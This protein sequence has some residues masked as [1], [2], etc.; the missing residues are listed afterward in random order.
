MNEDWLNEVVNKNNSTGPGDDWLSDT[1]RK[2]NAMTQYD[3]LFQPIAAPTGDEIGTSMF[4]DN[5]PF[6]ELD[7]LNEIRSQRQPWISKFGAGVGRVGSKAVSEILKM[8]GVLAG[9]AAG[10]VNE[11]ADSD[12]DFMQT[13]FNN[14]WVQAMNNLNEEVNEELLPVYVS[15]A[16]KEG[17][18]WDNITSIDFWA[19][20]GADGLG[21]IAS[22]LAPGAVINKFGIGAKAL[23]GVNKLANMANKTDDAINVLSKIGITP[24][25]ADLH[26]STLAN[27]VF[28]AGAEAGYAMDSYE[29]ELKAQLDAGQISF[30][31]YNIRMSKSSEIGRN[32]F[33]SNAAILL[34]PNA[35]MSK[36]LWGKPR[37]KTPNSLIGN[38]GFIKKL[39][40]LTTK[41]KL[42]KAGQE[43]GKGTLREGFFE[44][45]LQSTTESYFTENPEAN[46]SDFMGDL[47]SSYFEML[48]TT[49]GQKAILL[50][51][52][53][54]GGMQAITNY[55]RENKE[56]QDTNDLIDKTNDILNDFY[57]V[58]NED[59]YEKTDAGNI[60]YKN[61]K[62]VL[63]HYKVLEK[64]QSLSSMED[65]SELYDIALQTSNTDMLDKIEDIVTTNLVKPFIINDNMGTDVLR[66]S[67]E[68]QRKNL[69]EDK[70][71]GF[72]DK[73]IKKADTLKESY[74]LFN[75]FS[76]DLIKLSNKKATD[77]DRSDY[78]NRLANRYL[79]IN[80]N[81]LNIN[82]NLD[83]LT[84]LRRKVL[85]S[86]GMEENLVTDDENLVKAEK[87]DRRLKIINDKI[88][89]YE[90]SLKKV[91]KDLNS[92]W[93][94]NKINKEF[95]D[96]I[97]EKEKLE[98][99]KAK[100]KEVDDIINEINNATKLEDLDKIQTED[101]EIADIINIKKDEKRAELEKIQ[102]TKDVEDRNNS[103]E[104]E[105]DDNITKQNELSN[106]ANN[107]NIG[108]TVTLSV[109]KFANQPLK[110]KKKNK[111]SITF[112]TEK[113]NTVA[114]TYEDL[115]KNNRKLNYS[116][117]G[118]DNTKIGFST[119]KK[120]DKI[121]KR[122]DVKIISTNAND[123]YNALPFVDQKVVDYERTPIDKK[124]NSVSLEINNNINNLSDK[125]KQALDKLNNKDFS[126]LE[127]LYNHLPINVKLNDSVS[128][129][130]ATLSEKSDKYNAIFAKGTKIFRKKIID[131]LAKGV[132]ISSITS[133]IVGQK[134][135]Q[136]QLE[137]TVLENPLTGLYEIGNDIKKLKSNNFYV[138]DDNGALRNVN[139]ELMPASRQLAPGEV[140]LKIHT[141][142]GS[143]F[144]LKLNVK[145]VT[146]K[147][148]EALYELYKYR[149]EDI[150]EGKA[151]RIIDTTE[152][153]QN[154]VKANLQSEVEW[155]SKNK[156]KFEDL[157]I[158]DIVDFIIWDG[159]K[160]VKSQVRFVKGKLYVGSKSYTKEQFLKSKDQFT[161]FLVNNKRQH[162]K[163]KRTG[164]EGVNTPNFENRSYLEYLIN[165][166]ILNTNAK[167]NEPTFAEDT[168]IYISKDKIKV[169]G[170]IPEE[171]QNIFDQVNEEPTTKVQINEKIPTGINLAK[172]GYAVPEKET[173]SASG[174][175]FLTQ[176][177][178]DTVQKQMQNS[179]YFI[180]STNPVGYNGKE[181]FITKDTYYLINVTDSKIE[182]SIKTIENIIDEINSKF[183]G[184]KDIMK[185]DEILSIWKNRINNTS[186]KKKNIKKKN[187]KF[188]TSKYS[189]K[190]ADTLRIKLSI[191]YPQ[192]VKSLQMVGKKP[193]TSQEKL[194]NTI[195]FL[196]DKNISLKDIKTKCG[197]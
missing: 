194:D 21:Y 76:N 148:A 161:D 188:D 16:I 158:K 85:A 182:E 150:S 41:Q 58:F 90:E 87:S 139:D 32:I 59:V 172:L 134:N 82:E 52:A 132:D 25:N 141:A 65:I 110:V 162:I 7:E 5:V 120:D 42:N 193:G 14:G 142:N 192:Y 68:E 104:K 137:E 191:S 15:K 119:T 31:E 165:N 114:I 17:N 98:K 18:L 170:K 157:T 113:G 69:P 23:K 115:S 121:S 131:Q 108:E 116:T 50:G 118:T 197:L 83:Y 173:N 61:G 40:P 91:N 56:I 181:Y 30:D 117:E 171:N 9:M 22:M 73:I 196:L 175:K 6:S 44:E 100:E 123:N 176:K 125:Q 129:P 93:S 37:N 111:N 55:N 86:K 92:F 174:Y 168:S 46:L 74:D 177:D 153:V 78:Y 1:V 187:D 77:Q 39:D 88:R 106:I 169:N 146:E 144:P 13:A 147:Q 163:Y 102:A 97:S 95:N 48:D 67:L 186:S 33:L 136:I 34:G 79:N 4:D 189:D 43:F 2:N 19:T 10:V 166:N 54:G 159:T 105:A 140:Y 28:E 38:A 60:R 183:G 81:K 184:G 51:A 124:G 29:E 179:D 180:S 84:D 109:G 8:P 133:E 101:Q 35:M 94:N 145:R 62:P 47:A 190:Q 195:K 72:I 80:S 127:F 11:I 151:T 64:M 135:G 154:I 71:N 99:K 89:S 156:K 126:D 53:F 178:L 128:A 12:N 20:E 96:I 45:G 24:K 107:Y 75:A 36:M 63:D 130:I 112:E 164:E 49:E 143:E 26:L 138:V 66:A 167:I 152:D 3:S 57:T 185:K 103:E 149:F 155:F 27:T 160:N 122:Y 70:Q